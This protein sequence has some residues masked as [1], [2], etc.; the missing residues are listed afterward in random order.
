MNKEAEEFV[1]C[2]YNA[3]TESYELSL[4]WWVS[5]SVNLKRFQLEALHRVI[6]RTLYEA[7]DEK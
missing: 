4:F 3:F 1:S 7:G 5:F 6:G 2:K